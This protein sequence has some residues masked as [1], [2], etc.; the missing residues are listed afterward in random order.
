MS[1]TFGAL[2]LKWANDAC[3]IGL[4][5]TL[6]QAPPPCSLPHRS[7][8]EMQVRGRGCLASIG[9][10]QPEVRKGYGGSRMAPLVAG[11]AAPVRP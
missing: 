3:W 10:R 6:G 5:Q 1:W 11:A 4:N 9:T 8:A 7:L 2:G